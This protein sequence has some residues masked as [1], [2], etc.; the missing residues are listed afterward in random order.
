MLSKDELI[1]RKIH[2]WDSL[3]TH[4]GHRKSQSGKK[5]NWLKYPTEI[6]NI[7]LRLEVGKRNIALNFDIQYNDSE[8]REVFWEQLLELQ[9]VLENE[10][11]TDTIWIENCSSD[12]VACFCRIRWEK[13][14]LNFLN[15]SDFPEIFTFF[16]EKLISFDNFYQNFK[17]ILLFLAK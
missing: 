17:E 6:K 2:F 9:K 15:E 7:Y 3:K 16:K 13:E 11:G 12:D 4:I 5:I 1:A 14:G 8:I 10:M